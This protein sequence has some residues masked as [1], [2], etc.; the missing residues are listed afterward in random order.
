MYTHVHSSIIH[1][2]LKVEVI[3]V[4]VNR[5]MHKQNVVC[6]YNMETKYSEQGYRTPDCQMSA[7][8]PWLLC[9]SQDG[10]TENF[11]D[12]GSFEW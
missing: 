6:L 8:S 4:S 1:S 12:L 3:Q 10:V 9:D 11:E 2:D 5:R 7:L